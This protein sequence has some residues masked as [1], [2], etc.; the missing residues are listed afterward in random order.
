MRR[1]PSLLALAL[2]ALGVAVAA[3]GPTGMSGPSMNNKLGTP[4]TATATVESREILEREPRAN[5]T[6]VKHILISWKAKV[7]TYK[8]SDADPRALGRDKLGAEREVRALQQ[9]LAAGADFDT[10]MKAH[11]E[12]RGSAENAEAY[13]VAPDAQLVIE[14][15]QL[16]LR[17]DVDEVGVVESD[18]GFH[19]IKRVE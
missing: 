6:K 8:G 7:E 1:A 9:Q 15:R 2:L 13:D 5:H 10:L 3:C 19:I 18:F 17:L 12:D 4:A 16:G 14:F 11:S